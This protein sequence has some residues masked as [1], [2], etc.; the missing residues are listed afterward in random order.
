MYH[1]YNRISSGE[2]V[3][4]DPEEAI[5]FINTVRET[6]T[7]DGWTVLAW[8]VMSNHYHLVVRTATVP[9]WRGMHRV[10]NLFSR[11]FNIRHGR[12]GSLWQSRY[13]AKYVEDQSYLDR[14]ILYVHLNPVKAGLVEEPTDYVFGGHREVKK[15]VSSPLIDI[16][17]MMLCFGP[18]RREARRAYL[19]AI[20]AGI[21]S[22]GDEPPVRW[23][24]FTTK[25]DTPIEVDENPVHV[26]FLGRSTDLERPTL[27]AEDFVDLLC[28][29]AELDKDRLASR[30]RDRETA[31]MRRL[32]VTLG[33]ERWRQRGTALAEVLQK[34]ADVV[35]WW[36]GEG[37]RRRLEDEVFAKELDRLDKELSEAVA[38]GRTR[39]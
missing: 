13:K 11:R 19:S 15:L 38:H 39:R 34:N 28:K 35:S 32:V 37:V 6:K 14:L 31:S 26:D 25:I 9:L 10:Q 30:A 21:K 23:H 36:V 12:T 8:C 22:G 3:F 17:E 20:R 2:A 18:K 1:V 27:N 5:E 29:H 24:P 16:D 7:R 33:V 4:S